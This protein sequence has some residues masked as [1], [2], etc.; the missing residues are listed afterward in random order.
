[1]TRRFLCPLIVK[2]CNFVINVLDIVRKD[3]FQIMKYISCTVK[4]ILVRQSQYSS[5]T[6]ASGNENLNIPN[7][8]SQ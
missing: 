3:V 8:T 4:M 1:M 2:Y 7:Y 5:E 6:K